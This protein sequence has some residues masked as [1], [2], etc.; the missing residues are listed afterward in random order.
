MIG[1]ILVLAA[2][3]GP[4]KAPVIGSTGAPVDTSSDPALTV[5]SLDEVLAGMAKGDGPQ[6]TCFAW[7]AGT[8]T[9][10][11]AVDDS[12]IQGGAT[13]AVR[14]LG[15]RPSEHPYYQHPDDQQFFD[16]DLT[17]IDQAALATV[18]DKLA[19]DG[20]Q[21]YGFRTVELAPGGEL[22]LG[23]W[24]LRRTRTETGSDG[25]ELTGV[26]PVSTDRIEARCGAAWVPL[27]LSEQSFGHPVE[28]ATIAAIM[29]PTER[30]VLTAT[31]GWGVEGD[32]GGATD[33]VLLDDPCRR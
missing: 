31:V 32:S 13:A 15:G 9:A 19:S 25:H 4:A 14:F 28:A 10:A 33:A 26:W 18:K 23:A 8:G 29:L 2:C 1:A 22:T 24:T 16:Y 20:F 21:P 30:L 17:L 12:S 6:Q 3:G 5:P 27:D 7:S 11:C